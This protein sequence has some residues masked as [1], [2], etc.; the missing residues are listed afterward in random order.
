[1]DKVIVLVALYRFQN[2]PVR[3]L[4]S[5]IERVPGVKPYT[6]FLKDKGSP[7]VNPLTGKEQ[8]IFTDLISDLKPGLVGISV[9]SP[10]LPTA[11]KVTSIVR[12]NLDSLVLW[13]GLHPTIYPESCIKDA[14]LLCLGEGEGAVSDLVT[15]LR[16]GAPYDHI[17]NLWARKSDTVTKNPFRPLIQDLDSLPY[18][19]NKNK[20]YYFI[21]SNRVSK[22]DSMATDSRFF[23]QSSRGCPY[24]CSFCI[25]GILRQLYKD[26]GPY[27]RRRSVD[28]VLNEIKQ[29]NKVKYVTFCDETFGGE[30]K[31][32]SEF[33]ERFKKEIGLPFLI[34]CNP[35]RLTVGMLDRIVKAGVDTI[36]FGIQTGSDL[37]RSQVYNRAGK[38]DQL[39]ALSRQI[40]GRGV[41]IIYDLILD[42]PYESEE[43]F[44]DAIRLLL[45]LPKPLLFFVHALQYFPNYPLTNKAIADNYLNKEE[46]TSDALTERTIR[47]WAFYPRLFPLSS[48]HILENIIWLIA[49]NGAKDK[50]VNYAVFEDG[51]FPKICLHYLNL[52]AFYTGQITKIKDF[53]V[54]KYGWFAYVVNG[55]GYLCKGDF[56]LIYTKLNKHIAGKTNKL[57]IQ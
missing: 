43:T 1:M 20:D 6:I 12:N 48:K 23:I 53:L 5:I 30:E 13:G 46:A 40:S 15:C 49:N 51:L 28:S 14:D 8:K 29:N 42:S 56:K 38:N 32:L 35:E 41:K 18:A 31:W 26:L 2:F 37:I 55:M 27:T 33:E 25:N 22:N 10:F 4:H 57:Q 52:K 19:S 39:V 3:I 7:G 21:E 36:N 16:D 45:Q 17:K 24:T 44:K 34:E 47:N 11:K 54:W 50:I 9:L